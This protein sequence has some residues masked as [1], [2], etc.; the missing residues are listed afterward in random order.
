MSELHI[1]IPGVGVG[2]DDVDVGVGGGDLGIPVS[3][4]GEE[5]DSGD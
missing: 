1:P 4:D 2:V 5:D 3:D